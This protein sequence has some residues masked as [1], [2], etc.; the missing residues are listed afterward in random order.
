MVAAAFY[1]NYFPTHEL[2]QDEVLRQLNCKN[3]MSTI[4]V[5]SLE[6]NY[7]LNIYSIFFKL[8]QIKGLPNDGG[9]LYHRKIKSYLEPCADYMSIY[10]DS[11]K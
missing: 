6:I 7:H 11:M 2:N 5:V 1:P 10:Y 3:P 4:Q 8:V 9:I